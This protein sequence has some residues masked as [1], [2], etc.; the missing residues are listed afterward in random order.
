MNV[1]PYIDGGSTPLLYPTIPEAV[2]ASVAA[3]SGV[4]TPPNLS[5]TSVP[6]SPQ[7][8]TVSLVG[9]NSNRTFLLIYN[10]TQMVAQ[11]SKGIATQGARGNL[12]IG[13]GQAYFWAD[14]QQL[15]KVYQGAL[16]AVGL[17]QPLPLWVWE[18]GTNFY[19]DGGV[20]A[21][22][23]T[24]VGW[25]TSPAGLPYGAVWANDTGTV[26][27]APTPGYMGGQ[28]NASQFDLGQFNVGMQGYTPTPGAPPLFFGSITAEA[29]L[30]IGGGNLPLTDPV[31]MNQ[32]WNN[33]GE[34]AISDGSGTPGPGSF[35]TDAFSSGF[36]P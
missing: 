7:N 4:P 22:R 9:Q 15:G 31:V 27:I 35:E 12:S 34:V 10:P 6:L 30:A 20:L 29:L 13:P 2:L 18:D 26:G 5:A 14:A 24:P 11:F 32:L 36:G 8:T 19:N 33:G 28:V 21:F 3:A 17:Y 25:P 16:T 23:F 1:W